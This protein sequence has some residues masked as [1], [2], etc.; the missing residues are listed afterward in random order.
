[1]EIHVSVSIPRDDSLVIVCGYSHKESLK[2]AIFY[3]D[4]NATNIGPNYISPNSTRTKV[5]SRKY[6]SSE[7][8]FIKSVPAGNHVLTVSTD[9]AHPQHRSSLSHIIT[10][11]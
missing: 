3:L 9:P 1:M 11:A 6:H 10:F 4:V 7:C 2:H 5:T 8:T